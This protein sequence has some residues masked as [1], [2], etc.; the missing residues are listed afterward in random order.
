MVPEKWLW[1][2]H[3]DASRVVLKP[4]ETS[5]FSTLGT[6]EWAEAHRVRTRRKDLE[7]HSRHT[8]ALCAPEHGVLCSPDLG[9]SPPPAG[10]S[11]SP[12][13]LAPPDC[14]AGAQGVGQRH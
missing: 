4:W 11:S 1:K 9:E 6:L 8:R 7:F 5:C 13:A 2:C 10:S 3:G 12:L 14:C